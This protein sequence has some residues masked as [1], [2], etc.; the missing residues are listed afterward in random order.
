[1]I[2]RSVKMKEWVLNNNLAESTNFLDLIYS[3]VYQ[4][5]NICPYNNKYKIKRFHLGW[6]KCG[7]ANKCQCTKEAI[8]KNVS[9]T[10]Q[11]YTVEENYKINAKRNKTM[12]MKYG[13]THNLKRTE[14]KE[15]LKLPK[16]NNIISEKLNN[17]KWLINEHH[18][19]RKSLVTIGIEL[20]VYYGT[21]SFYCRKH[22][23]EIKS[24]SI[25]GSEKQILKY[26]PDTKI[27]TNTRSIIRPYELDIYLPEYNIAIEYNGIY[28][29]RPAKF[30]SKLQWFIYHQNKEELCNSLGIKLLHLWENYGDH[31]T[32][33]GEAINGN[34]NNNLDLAFNDIIWPK[35][36]HSEKCFLTL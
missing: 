34:I 14:V 6:S 19:K 18:T 33:I 4:E 11:K 31:E 12:L 17:K 23:I 16:I 36:K 35:K 2:Q 8:S 27:I 26:L 21:V 13:V 24:R 20:D 3:A 25:S 7:P 32:L 15:K 9:K 22:N 1:M 10:K 28:W 5:S 29:H 30:G